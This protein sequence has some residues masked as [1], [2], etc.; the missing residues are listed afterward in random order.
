MID[1]EAQDATITIRVPE[2]K[3]K[4]IEKELAHRGITNLSAWLRSLVEKELFQTVKETSN[5]K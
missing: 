5:A 1:R 2:I 4:K 3:K